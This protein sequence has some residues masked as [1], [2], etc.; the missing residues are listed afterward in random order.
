MREALVLKK[1]KTAEMFK[2]LIQATENK[3]KLE[4]MRT[5]I[6]EMNAALEEKKLKI[7]VN[8]EDAKML[9]LNVESVDAGAKLI[10]Q[11]VCDEM[12]QWQKDELIYSGGHSGRGVDDTLI[13]V[14]MA[15]CWS[16]I[17]ENCTDFRTKVPLNSGI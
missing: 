10:V 17:A 4:E 12:L 9:S 2:L 3:L 5:M 15:G 11:S 7:A 16:G 6:E 14:K 8:A 13:G 1:K